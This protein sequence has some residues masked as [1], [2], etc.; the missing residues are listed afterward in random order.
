MCVWVSVRVHPSV[1]ICAC[2]LYICA[3]VYVAVVCACIL[4]ICACVYVVMAQTYSAPQ[5]AV[6]CPHSASRYDHIG[7]EVVIIDK[8]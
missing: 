1:C 2:I 8:T 6:E 5:T 4:Y 3:C 7:L